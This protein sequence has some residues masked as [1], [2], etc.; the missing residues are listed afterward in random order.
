[1]SC[2]RTFLLVYFWCFFRCQYWSACSQGRI[3]SS[4][5]ITALESEDLSFSSVARA[6]NIIINLAD[7]ELRSPYKN[8]CGSDPMLLEMSR[9]SEEM[10]TQLPNVQK[11]IEGAESHPQWPLIRQFLEDLLHL[12]SNEDY[13]MERKRIGKPKKVVF[14]QVH[15]PRTASK[16]RAHSGNQKTRSR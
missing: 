12:P 6:V 10:V 11:P 2:R 7:S 3:H 5:K 15:F 8:L 1:M 9:F 13:L 4:H 14:H 16:Y